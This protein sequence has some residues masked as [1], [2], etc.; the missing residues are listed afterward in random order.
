MALIPQPYHEFKSLIMTRQLAVL[1]CNIFDPNYRMNFNYIF[2]FF[3]MIS[4]LSIVAYDVIFYFWGDLKSICA[5][6]VTNTYPITTMVR[7]CNLYWKRDLL[8]ELLNKAMGPETQKLDGEEQFV[9]QKYGVWLKKFGIYNTIFFVS[10]GSFGIFVPY[11][12]FLVTGEKTLPYGFI[13]PGISSTQNPGYA[14]NYAYHMFQ[15]LCVLG[16]FLGPF[17]TFTLYVVNVCF[18]IE[19]I[20]IKLRRLDESLRYND[21]LTQ[22]NINEKI[23]IV[24]PQSGSHE[25]DHRADLIEIIK[26]HQELKVFTDSLEEIYSFQS[27]I[28]LFGIS[29]QLVVTLFV[30][31]SELWVTGFLLIATVTVLLFSSSMLGVI[32][33]IKADK[34]YDAIYNIAWH[35][36]KPEE[37]GMV[38]LLLVAAKNNQLLTCGGYFPLN[39][40]TF[41]RVS[42]ILESIKHTIIFEL[43]LG[44]QVSL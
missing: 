42:K 6:I 28:D 7:M 1:G 24:R 30:C 21:Y 18:Q 32:I 4:Y 38:V 9:Y 16:G 31:T 13:I 14:I 26:L 15:C 22:E 36:L 5:C 2:L 34:L 40:D 43:F 44:L 25:T 35:L 8:N 39:L 19:S 41:A 27:L 37:R 3:D 17:H 29:F 20:I 12:I 10:C 33:E 11:L 23:V